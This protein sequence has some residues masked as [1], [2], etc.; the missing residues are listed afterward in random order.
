[1]GKKIYKAAIIG[2]GRIAWKFEEIFKGFRGGPLTHAGAF[3]DNPYTKLTGGCSPDM[4]DRKSFEKRYKVL[5]HETVEELLA[6]T[7][8]DIVSICSPKEFHFEHIR[9]RIEAEVPMIWLEKPP[10]VSIEDM[11]YLLKKISRPG[12]RTKVLVNYQR[13]YIKRYQKLKE[14]CENRILGEVFAIQI[15][16]A[17]GLEQNGCH[18][19]DMAFF[20]IGDDQ[21]ADLQCITAMHDLE[22][23]S[24]LLHFSYG[25]PVHVAGIGAAYNIG[26][27]SLTCEH[28]RV[29]VIQGGMKTLWEDK[30]EHEL[31]K[32]FFRLKA[33]AKSPL[34]LG[35]MENGMREALADLINSYQKN[36]DPISNLNTSKNTQL[37][38]NTILKEVETGEASRHSRR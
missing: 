12:N 21:R 23:P 37:L 7:H 20:I 18:M 25:L 14:I 30:V 34:S 36:I 4:D 5:T 10:T 33:K 6:D 3:N 2:L 27:I 22:N 38:M 31:Y 17:R 26:D 29:S 13:R 9:T 28:G 15:S 35:A 8:P 16:Y 32:G 24:F 19:L 1:M 11:N